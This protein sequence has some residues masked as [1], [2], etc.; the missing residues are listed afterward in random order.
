MPQFKYDQ[1]MDPEGTS[2]A[3][4]DTQL[5]VE[6]TST[7][8]ETSDHPITK[9]K[10]EVLRSRQIGE[11]DIV[12]AVL[13]KQK[14]NELKAKAKEGGTISKEEEILTNLDALAKQES[15][16]FITDSTPDGLELTGT[17][18]EVYNN[19]GGEW[20]VKYLRGTEVNAQGE[21]NIICS[22]KYDSD[23][24]GVELIPLK[25]FTIAQLTAEQDAILSLFTPSEQKVI[26]LKL[27]HS[28]NG[29]EAL[30]GIS[31]DEMNKIITNG[32]ESAGIIT[33]D[34]VSSFIDTSGFTLTPDKRESINKMLDSQNIVDA[35]TASEIVTHLG[36]SPEVLKEQAATLTTSLQ[37]A[38]AL[39]QQD[40]SNA[41]AQNEVQLIRNQI[42]ILG[43]AAEAGTEGLQKY[44][45]KLESGEINKDTAQ[46]VAKAMKEGNINHALEQIIPELADNPDDTEEEKQNKLNRKIELAKKIGE[47]GATGTAGLLLLLWQLAAAETKV[48]KQSLK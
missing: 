46:N 8:Q 38:E 26:S 20:V 17:P 4:V 19:R 25:D 28:K 44:F 21:I 41:D 37:Q 45:S 31:D 6:N 30:S 40:P 5:P 3:Q 13:L 15:Q 27:S 22:V 43:Q 33:S 1:I 16:N 23:S 36:A 39:L 12:G 11:I 32:S 42:A 2:P 24:A 47:K 7:D 14:T 34:V 10:K 35:P 18:L 9:E 29:Q 48:I